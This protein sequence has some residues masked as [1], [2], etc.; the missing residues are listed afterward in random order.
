MPEPLLIIGIGNDS[1]GDDGLGWAF[2][3]AIARAGPPP[4][5]LEY[6]FQLL[7]EDAELLTR[8][9]RVLFA[10]ACE[11]PLSGGF[12]LEPCHPDPA[13]EIYTHQ[14]TPGAILCLCRELY[15]H[16]PEAW[17]LLIQGYEWAFDSGLSGQARVN[18]ANAVGFFGVW[19]KS[20]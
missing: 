17:H 11:I 20:L 13:A 16:R 19:R 18:L 8:F 7:V 5:P 9:P 6:R 1:R 3:D 15:G 12:A 10:D 2:L 4:G 14:Q